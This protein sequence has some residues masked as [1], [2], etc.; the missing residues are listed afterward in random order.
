[1]NENEQ[2]RPGDIQSAI[3]AGE[4]IGQLS[5][6]V[7]RVSDAAVPTVVL[8]P[9]ARLESIEH[10]QQVPSRLNASLT[11]QTAQSFVGYVNRFKGDASVIFANSETK[12]FTA[13]LDYHA[14]P[15][16]PSWCQHRAAFAPLKTPAWTDWVTNDRKP[17]PQVEFARFIE[18]H[19]P[20]IAEPAGADLLKLCL[21]LDAKKNVTFKQSNRLEDGQTQLVYEEEIKATAGGGAQKGTLDVPS[22]FILVLEPFRGVGGM[23]VDARF[24]Y[25]INEG[26]LT[27][28][29]ELVRVEDVLDQAFAA[30]VNTIVAGV[31]GVPVLD[32]I[33]PTK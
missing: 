22:G 19:I 4:R 1:M 20:H 12:G 14:S 28:W 13:V 21:T 9:G 25:R 31:G 5:N 11:L 7:T 18:D 26:A 32:G 8:A 23:R 30:I 10:L 27:L 16:T 29:Y 17:K 2:K 15:S 3:N 6:S 33:A 24:R